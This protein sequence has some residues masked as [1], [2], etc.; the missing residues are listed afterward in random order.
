MAVTQNLLQ[1]R[2]LSCIRAR[3]CKTRPNFI[4]VYLSYLYLNFMNLKLVF[5]ILQGTSEGAFFDLT[6]QVYIGHTFPS[7]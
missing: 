7:F 5:D 3:L 4:T 2:K 1:A 6:I